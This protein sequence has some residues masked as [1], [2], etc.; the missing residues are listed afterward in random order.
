MIYHNLLLLVFQHLVADVANGT[1]KKVF[2][3]LRQ[4]YC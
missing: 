2:K 3:K 4:E 1:R